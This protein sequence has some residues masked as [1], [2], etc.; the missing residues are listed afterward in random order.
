M[1]GLMHVQQ[2]LCHGAVLQPQIISLNKIVVLDFFLTSFLNPKQ[3]NIEIEQVYILKMTSIFPHLQMISCH[4]E[5]RV[6]Q[7]ICT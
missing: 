6:L 7:I 3:E 5:P 4:I 1:Q 2:A